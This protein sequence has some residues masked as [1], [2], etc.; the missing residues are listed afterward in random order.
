MGISVAGCGCRPV[1]LATSSV[2]ARFFRG[3]RC[4]TSIGAVSCVHCYNEIG[5]GRGNCGTVTIV[6]NMLATKTAI[7]TSSSPAARDISIEAASTCKGAMDRE[8]IR[9]SCRSDRD[10]T[11]TSRRVN[12]TTSTV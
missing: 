2:V 10:A 9:I 12:S 4:I 3:N 8:A 11:R 6:F 7:V 1:C 5:S